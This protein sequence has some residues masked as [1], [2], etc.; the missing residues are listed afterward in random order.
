LIETG[1]RKSIRLPGYDYSRPGAYF[2]TI[3]TKD[4]GCFFG[5]IVDQEMA[6]NDAGRI[7]EIVWNELPKF[8]LGVSTDAFQI[9]PNHVHGIIILNRSVATHVGAGPCACPDVMRSPWVVKRDGQRDGQRVVKRDG[10][11]R[12]VAPT[13]T[14]TPTG[15][16]LVLSLPDIVHRFKTMTT[17]RYA[18]GVK[19]HGWPRF[20]GKLW[21]R[22]YYEHIVRD[23]DELFRVREYIMNNPARW[24]TDRE[25]PMAGTT[26]SNNR[27]SY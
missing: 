17:K 27:T 24:A 8:Y 16:D 2:V 4:R 21:Q 22:N 20:P 15:I 9:M 5:E 13:T 10:Q 6:L 1:H 18:D 23:D 25:N 26:S 12:G 14:A 7:M 19:R 11:P 3:C